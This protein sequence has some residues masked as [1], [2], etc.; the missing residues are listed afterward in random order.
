MPAV[1]RKIRE[2]V[3]GH[4][5]FDGLPGLDRDLHALRLDLEALQDREVRFAR[6]ERDGERPVG[7]EGR[8]TPALTD[9]RVLVGWSVVLAVRPQEGDARRNRV[10]PARVRAHRDGEHARRPRVLALADL[11]P[12]SSAAVGLDE[13]E[14]R[15]AALVRDVGDRLPVGR[16]ARVERVVLEEGEF[17]RFS[18][19][20]RLHV[21]VVELVRRPRRRRVDE[22]PAVE[23]HVR[24]GAVERLLP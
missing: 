7:V 12:P 19:L 16:P 20:R 6:R 18:A 4:G 23:R 10:P 14:L 11:D 2:P 17:I 13:F 5:E 9:A 15:E 3:Q 21:Q 24:P 22:A 1:G 8:I